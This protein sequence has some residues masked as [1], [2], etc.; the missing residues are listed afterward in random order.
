MYPKR[1]SSNF[2][3]L[4]LVL[5]RALSLSLSIYP[6]NSPSFYCSLDVFPNNPPKAEQFKRM[7]TTTTMTTNWT[8]VVQ[9][10]RQINTRPL[11][12]HL[13]K[14]EYIHTRCRQLTDLCTT[15]VTLSAPIV[16]I[17]LHPSWSSSPCSSFG[18]S[19]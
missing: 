5:S 4:S 10:S 3:Y 19:S 12:Q 14:H 17:T 16:P 8:A 15:M 9:C 13:R 7:K 1:K 11:A 2:L 6:F 18:S